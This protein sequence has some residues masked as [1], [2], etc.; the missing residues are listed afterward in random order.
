M[1]PGPG[2]RR[3]AAAR[4]R[5]SA[6]RWAGST[7]TGKLM[8]SVLGGVAAFEREMML[9]LQREGI[10]KAKADGVYRGRPEDTKRNAGIARMLKA[11]TSWSEIL[12]TTGCSR[13]TIAKIA[14]RTAAE[15][16]GVSA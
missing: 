8:L 3:S 4:A 6:T 7:A 12:D 15:E 5:C 13:A 16:T 1:V 10:A 2:C 11:G 14:K 9:E